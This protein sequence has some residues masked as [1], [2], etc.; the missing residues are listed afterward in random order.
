MV[1]INSL[2]VD[3]EKMESGVWVPFMD[4]VE[5]KVARLGNR[6]FN[7]LVRKLTEPFRKEQRDGQVPDEQMEDVMLKATAKTLLL[8]WK[9]VED[10]NGKAL[11]YSAKQAYEWFKDGSLTN[12]YLAVQA[13]ANSQEIYRVEVDRAGAKN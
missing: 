1:K 5:I 3:P 10:E 4:G 9:G 13:T 8:D 11:K 7:T 2:R 12:L 6:S